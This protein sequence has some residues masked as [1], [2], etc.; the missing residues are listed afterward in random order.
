MTLTMTKE[1]LTKIIDSLHLQ[2]VWIRMCIEIAEYLHNVDKNKLKNAKNFWYLTKTSLAYRGL[3]ELAKLFDEEHGLSL[4]QIKNLCSRNNQVFNDSS[5]VE[6]C[7]YF[8]KELKAFSAITTKLH[9]R[10]N[11]SLAH[12]DIDYYF[13]NKKS[14]NDFNLSFEEIK[15]L[16]MVIYNFAATMQKKI[17]SPSKNYEYP[18]YY[19]DVKRLFGEKTETD[20]LLESE[21]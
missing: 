2:I 15:E 6:Y 17:D 1:E 21:W 8:E 12:N 9:T 3:M 11:K 5:V 4:K 18:T 20:I 14:V 19:D 7:R 10:R 16:A 13:Y